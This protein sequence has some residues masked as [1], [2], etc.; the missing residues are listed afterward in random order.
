MSDNAAALGIFLALLG[1]A[2]LGLSLVVLRLLPRA[3]PLA[4]AP[5][6]PPVPVELPEHEDAVLLVEAGGRIAYINSQARAWFRLGEDEPDLERLS[7]RARPGDVFLALCARQGRARITVDG[8]FVEG[9]SYYVPYGTG[10]AMLVSLSQPQLILQGQPDPA[11]EGVS[12][13]AELGQAM[14]VDQ[15]LENTLT[16]VLESVERLLPVDSIEAGIWDPDS[17]TLK[18]YRLA[19]PPGPERRLELE[20]T[21]SSDAPGFAGQVIAAGKLL[22]KQED[23]SG[24]EGGSHFVFRSLLGAPLFAAGE[25]FG[26]L[27]LASLSPDAFDRSEQEILR[28]LSGQ[29]AVAL[30]NALLQREA[31]RRSSA[32]AGLEEL[33]RPADPGRDPQVELTRLVEVAPLLE[34][35]KFGFFLYDETRQVLEAQRPFAGLPE[36]MLEWARVEI[37]PGSPAEAV[38][39]AG[40]TILVSD[41]AADLRLETLGLRPLSQAA[42]IKTAAL[43]PLSAGERVSGYLFAADKFGG[44]PF[45][46]DDL[47]LLHI[48]AGQASRM[49]ENSRKQTSLKEGLGRAEE[50]LQAA[51]IEAEAARK[52][53]Q[54][55]KDRD[56]ELSETLQ[57]SDRRQRWMAAC[58]RISG[59]LHRQPDAES[60][61][62][63]LGQE[64]Q[65]GLGLDTVLVVEA[66]SGGPRLLAAHGQIPEGVRPE[67]LLGQPS[68][69]LICLQNHR[70]I[71]AP[72]LSPGEERTGSPLLKS[73]EAAG[74]ICLPVVSGERAPRGGDLQGSAPAR[75]EYALLGVSRTPLPDTVQNDE[76]IFNLVSEQASIA[77]DNLRLVEDTNRRVEEVRLLLN[78]TRLLSSAGTFRGDPDELEGMGESYQLLA[79]SALHLIPAA[80]ACAVLTWDP[81]Q[82]ALLPRAAAGYRDNERL[83][84]VRHRLEDTPA[85]R[86]FNLGE[87]VRMDEVDFAREY[88]LAAE[89]LLRYSEAAGGRLP[90]SNLIVPIRSPRVE[91]GGPP[92]LSGVLLLENFEQAAVFTPEAE[93]LIVSLAQQTALMLEN[94]RLYRASEQRAAQLDALAQASVVLT[95]TL[96]PDLLASELLGQLGRVMVFDTGTLW[97]R[98]GPRMVVRAAWGFE[99]GDE[100]IGLSAAVEDS[101]LLNEM[102][103]TGRPIVVADLR[104]DPRFPQLVEH[105]RLSWLGVPLIAGREVIGVIALEKA[106]ANYFTSE[107]V[108]IAATFAGQAAA[109]VENAGLYAESVARAQELDQRSQRLALL[110]QL[111]SDLGASLDPH[112]ILDS[113]LQ[114]LVELIGCDGAAAVLFD[115]SGAS[116]MAEAGQGE[117][118]RAGGSLPAPLP[119]APLFDRLR[120]SLGIYQAEDA[121]GDAALAPLAEYLDRREACSLL[122]LPL[123]TGNDL[124]GLLLALTTEIHRFSPEEVS[125]A[126]TIANQAAVGVENARLYAETRSLSQDLERRVIE[127]TAQLG[128]EH[129]RTQTLLKVLTELSSSLDLDH[130]LNRTLGVLNELMDARHISVLIARPGENRLYHLASLGYAD[131]P[132]APRR[133]TDL[134][135]V[136][137]LAGWVIS[138]GKAALIDDVT[139][140]SRWIPYVPREEDADTGGTWE[141]RSVIGAPLMVGA[142][143]LGALLFFHPQP[144]HFSVDQI[145]LV[146]AV[147]R[148]VAVAVN[149]AELYRLIRDQA[150]DLGG[151]LRREQVETSRTRA[152]LEAVADGVLVTDA[153]R[154]ITL[155][156][157]SAEEILG[158]GRGEVIGR[159]LED[160]LGLF[161]RAA[162]DW[163]E[164][165]HAWSQDPAS[166]HPGEIFSAQVTLENGRVV[167]V[168]LAP[169][170]ARSERGPGRRGGRGEFLGTVSIFRDITHQVEVDRLKSEFVATVSHEL[171]TPMTAI[172]GYVDVLRMGAAG[173]VSDQQNRFLSTIQ[174]NTERLE[175]L[176]DDLLDISQIEAGRS[177]ISLGPVDLAALAADRVSEFRRRSEAAGKGL[178]L[179][180]A[181]ETGLPSA[182]GDI[183]RVRQVLD[184]LLENAYLYTPEGGQICVRLQ[185]TGNELQVEV[186]D[187]GIGIPPELHNRVF[188][189]FFRGEHP[190][191][192][193]SSGTGLGLS[194]VKNLVEMQGGR[195]W[196]ESSGAPGAGSLFTFTLPALDMKANE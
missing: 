90:V 40:E 32:L 52:Q 107:Q 47:R 51:V 8:R 168:H 118:L 21:R 87:P 187:S 25:P 153:R 50:A 165:I 148:Q 152:I 77:L 38:L 68:P 42:G 120:E 135:P 97:L 30:H 185:H 78:F 36:G 84:E 192:L 186:Q 177:A 89:D 128:R 124:H 13:F 123:V 112:R 103:Q 170:Q 193:A 151:M 94:A 26:A 105:Q 157:A 54:S 17:R 75:A 137:S 127:R 132:P 81:A 2:V 92:T 114:Y 56:R 179:E 93:A 76:Y 180:L 63:V 189:R 34:V 122:A 72:R 121:S 188:E 79:E 16:A 175:A 44:A 116:L 129:Q 88:R 46:A 9:T 169:V 136:E 167:S 194:I 27:V 55:L 195:I 139:A 138:N 181:V 61:L 1:M 66:S 62:T 45:D 67:T 99:D 119:H 85:G 156:N 108:L 140:D 95:S 43:L 178:R 4:L 171:R 144:G 96:E 115:S 104:R 100:R 110:N 19:G 64:L 150:E 101:L 59:L 69:L 53:A 60:V 28:I 70:L 71:L 33:A 164:T 133:A 29:A 65:S 113:A 172:K 73:L 111:S 117:L 6:E 174:G 162:Q 31:Q 163:V 143:A 91:E 154:K 83:L 160:F 10:R 48:I 18:V 41:S 166:Y 20:E 130:I 15:D 12:V 23:P 57:Q 39:S 191:V 125:L 58:L 35:E 7:R 161:G 196:L 3:R 190:F 146:E 147:A 37:R 142:E 14:A 149:N 5:P 74:I 86:A 155:F 134:H 22:Q 176:V 145:D 131:A 183:E 141:R 82:E 24:S 98:Q 126:R 182:R 184:N 80:Q 106:E 102:A 158:L 11:G 109:A 173:P 49:V 159:S